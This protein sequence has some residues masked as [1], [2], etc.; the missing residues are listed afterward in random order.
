MRKKFKS[1]KRIKFSFSLFVFISLF[2]LLFSVFFRFIVS[3]NLIKF[4]VVSLI[5]SSNFFSTRSN[6]FKVFFSLSRIDINNPSTILQSAMLYNSSNDNFMYISN[7][8]SSNDINVSNDNP[9]VYIY[10]T[11][12]TE[13]YSDNYGVYDASFY[14]RDRLYELG[15]GSIVE[16]N[17]TSNV[18]NSNGWN[19]NLS[20]KASRINLERVK[21]DN[22]SIRIFID[23]HRDSVSYNSSFI[24]IGGKGYAKVLFV[25]GRE[26]SNYLENFYYTQSIDYMINSSY[27]GLSKGVLEKEGPSVNGIYNQDVGYNVILLEVGGSENSSLEVKNTLDAVSLIIKEKVYEEN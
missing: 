24:N 4:D 9:L 23:L 13:L 7:D 17:R 5:S 19:Y 1:R 6:F 8:N 21:N 25:I 12:D 20:Y 14:L 18:L 22:P 26:H 2:L 11:H 10:N 27:P 3:F 16:E 15:I